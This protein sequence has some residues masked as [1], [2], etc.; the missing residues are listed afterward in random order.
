M[1]FIGLIYS[2]TEWVLFAKRFFESIL[3]VQES[4]LLTVRAS[5]MKGRTLI[6]ADPRVHLPW[7]YQADVPGFEVKEVVAVSELRADPEAIARKMLRRIF[8]LF[9]WND[10]DENMLKN[11]QQKLILRQY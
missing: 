1:S 3:A 7:E 2:V 10:P 8:E 4:V 11:W 6:S 5:G 9:N